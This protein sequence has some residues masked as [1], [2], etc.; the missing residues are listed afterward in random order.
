MLAHKSARCFLV[1]CDDYST[2]IFACEYLI[3]NRRISLH[4]MHRLNRP[5]L[6]SRRWH[7]SQTASEYAACILFTS[8]SFSERASG[9]QFRRSRPIGRS[10]VSEQTAANTLKSLSNSLNSSNPSRFNS[11]DAASI[12]IYSPSTG[13]TYGDDLTTNK[14]LVVPAPI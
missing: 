3:K 10:S 11:Q 7:P 12:S 5:N 6:V 13:V 4:Q 9:C 1:E 14:I 2:V 8:S